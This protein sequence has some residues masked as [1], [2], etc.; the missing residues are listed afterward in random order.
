MRAVT[1]EPE[2]AGDVEVRPLRA[3]L[4]G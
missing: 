3:V 4:D 1:I 2:G